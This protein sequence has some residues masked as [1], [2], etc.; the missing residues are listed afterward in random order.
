MFNSFP[1]YN[2]AFLF[3]LLQSLLLYVEKKHIVV[4]APLL[5]ETPMGSRETAL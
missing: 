1:C 4:S 3:R 2:E 5:G